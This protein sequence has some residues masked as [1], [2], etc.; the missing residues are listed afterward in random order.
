MEIVQQLLTSE[1]PMIQLKTRLQL[2]DQ[3]FEDVDIKQICSDLKTKS[4]I[5]SNLVSYLPKSKEIT[6]YHVYKKWQGAHWILVDLADIGYPPGDIELI[7]T[8]HHELEWLLSIQ[9][10]NRKKTLEGRKRFCASQEGNGLYSLLKLELLDINEDACKQLSNRLITYQWEDGGW[11]CDTRPKAINSS[12]HESL[13]PLRALNLYFNRTGSVRAKTAVEKGCELFLKRK[14]YKSL[15]T[16]NNISS[17]WTQ[18]HYPPY[19]RYDILFALKVL[20]ES[21]KIK[22]NRCN[23][24]LD[25]LESKE[26]ASGGFPA[27]EKNY[28]IAPSAKKTTGF[29]PVDWGGKNIKKMN[30]WITIDAL[31]VLKHAGRI[32]INMSN[33]SI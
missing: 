3:T 6:P 23:D 12:Y 9:R 16:G 10:W 2:F 30:P 11:N 29:S 1:E 18:L 4:S 28:S 7:P 17:T 32:D 15:G 19:W 5:I 20:A 26:L 24:A 13:I 14:L 33:Y 25:L 8:K 31:Y 22:D 27:E 21:K